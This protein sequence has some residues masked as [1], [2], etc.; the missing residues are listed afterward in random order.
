[1]KFN[2]QGCNLSN[3]SRLSSAQSRA[4]TPENFSGEKGRGGAASDGAGAYAARELGVG[5]KVSP[6][7][8]IP[9]QSKFVMADIDGAG[10][11]QHIW[12]TLDHKFW[13][14]VVLRIYWEG[15]TT[16]AVCAPV[17]DFFCNGWCEPTLINSLAIT[18]NPRGGFNSYFEMPFF[19]H[20]KIEM[21][22]LA[23]EQVYLYYQVDYVRTQPAEGS[24]YFHAQ[25]NRTNPVPYK[26]DY[27]IL[28]NVRGRGHYVGTYMAR[29]VNSNMWWGEGEMKF[30]M[31]GDKEFPTICGTGTEDYFG[32]AWNFEQPMGKYGAYSTAYQGFA[33]MSAPDGLY[34]ANTRFSMYRWHIA[35]PVRFEQDLKVTV[36]VLGWRS[37]SR[38]L[39]LQDDVATVAYWYQDS[40]VNGQR[41]EFTAD[42]MEVI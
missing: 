36:Q 20:A 11:I 32:G 5:W 7:V 38:Y 14:S 24:A 33:P 13:R 39:P 30:Y 42:E 1:M 25:W 28:E 8:I 21:E 40:P 26:Q 29:Q 15:E 41:H 34:K 37:G 18:V 35:D 22:N 3:L 6:C 16:P 17:G 10:I 27:V 12:L 2:G 23:P 19:R 31:D 9:P 4:I